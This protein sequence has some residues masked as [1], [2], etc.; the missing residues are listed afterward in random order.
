[1]AARAARGAGYPIGQA[2]DLGNT[3]LYLAGVRAD[4]TPVTSAL[5]EDLIPPQVTW[6]GNDAVITAG[7]TITT[8]PIAS[9]VIAMGGQVTIPEIRQAPLISAM[10][11]TRG[12][13]PWWEGNVLR[14]GD[15]EILPVKPGPIDV[16]DA[17]W[18]IWC[19]LAAKTY[20]PDSAASRA[21][22]AGAGLTDND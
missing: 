9:D 1:M 11:C 19:D 18:A 16:A 4:I 15:C 20:V 3:A 22:G 5:L 2:E 14:L 8:A 7:S 21:A 13:T 10:L 6:A 17:D 12:L